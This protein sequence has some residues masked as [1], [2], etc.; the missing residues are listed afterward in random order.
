MNNRIVENLKERQRLLNENA[1]LDRDLHLLKKR[2]SEIQQRID[3]IDRS[4]A[5]QLNLLDDI[6]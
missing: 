4:N 5:Q 6:T 3:E 1:E 2:L